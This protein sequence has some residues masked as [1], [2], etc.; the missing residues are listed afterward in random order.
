MFMISQP[1]GKLLLLTLSDVG[2]NTPVP[3]IVQLAAASMGTLFTSLAGDMGIKV[4]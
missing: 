2:A 4:L 3:V 1:L